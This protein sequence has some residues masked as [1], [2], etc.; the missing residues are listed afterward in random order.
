MD[1]D[2]LASKPADLDLYSFKTGYI[3]VKKRLVVASRNAPYRNKINPM[4]T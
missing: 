3:K 1:P 2:K 4:Y